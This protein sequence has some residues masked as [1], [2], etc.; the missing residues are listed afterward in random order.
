MLMMYRSVNVDLT[1]ADEEPSQ[2]VISIANPASE[3]CVAQ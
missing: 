3:Y 2:E 1:I